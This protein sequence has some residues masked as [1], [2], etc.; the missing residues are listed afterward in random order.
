V[1]DGIKKQ[2]QL[3]MI[4]ETGWSLSFRAAVN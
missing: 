3:I 1:N 4:T 2:Q